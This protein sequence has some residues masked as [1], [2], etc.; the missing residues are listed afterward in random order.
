MS[1]KFYSWGRNHFN[2]IATYTSEK[3]IFYPSYQP[4]NLKITQ[5]IITRLAS[6]FYLLF[7]LISNFFQHLDRIWS[8]SYSIAIGYLNSSVLNAILCIYLMAIS[9]FSYPTILF[10]GMATASGSIYTWGSNRYG[11]YIY[12]R[13]YISTMD[14]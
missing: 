9:S 10:P 5:V 3:T 4:I 7:P 14:K 8:C 1:S 2:C 12:I 11:K 13:T 6:N